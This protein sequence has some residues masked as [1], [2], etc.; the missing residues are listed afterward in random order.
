MNVVTVGETGSASERLGIECGLV[1]SYH[2]KVSLFH[3]MN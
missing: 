3:N 2:A 1:E